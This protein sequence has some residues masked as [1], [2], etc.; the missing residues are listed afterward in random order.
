MRKSY[1]TLFVLGVIFFILYIGVILYLTLFDREVSDTYQYEWT[2]FWSYKIFFEGNDVFGILIMRNILLFIP[3]GFLLALIMACFQTRNGRAKLKKT[4]LFSTLIGIGSSFII[5]GCQ[6][7]F[8]LGLFEFD[9]VINNGLG[10][11][12][13]SIVLALIWIIARG[14]RVDK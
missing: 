12:I 3:F 9:D 6:L 2:P 4:V 1:K 5:E 8:K 7:V 14:A 10:A 11:L 13:G